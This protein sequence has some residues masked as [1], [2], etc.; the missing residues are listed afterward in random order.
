MTAQ[1]LAPCDNNTIQ[2]QVTVDTFVVPDALILSIVTKEKETA[3]ELDAIENQMM[4]ILKALGINTEEAFSYSDFGSQLN[5]K[6]FSKDIKQSRNYELKLA[7][8]DEAIQ[9][10]NELNKINIGRINL[11]RYKYT[12]EDELNLQLRSKAILRAKE[13]AVAL[14]A[15]IGQEV[16]NAIKIVDMS[17]D[18]MVNYMN[19]YASAE[20]AMDGYQSKQKLSSP[21]FKK[22]KFTKS[23]YVHFELK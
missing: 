16:G 12:G 11:S 22:I 3:K 20:V 14:T 8:A 7:T 4:V 21:D 17:G 6:L 1:A 18:P 9:V 10:I 15:P 2:T 5:K 13:H 23:L 19:S